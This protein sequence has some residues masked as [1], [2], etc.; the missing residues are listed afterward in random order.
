MKKLLL[1]IVNRYPPLFVAIQMFRNRTGAMRC[2]LE[3]LHSD[4]KLELEFE[5]KALDLG[6]GPAPKNMFEAQFAV[7]ADRYTDEKKNVVCVDL[8]FERLP[9]ED[10]WFHYI[11][12]YDLLEHIPRF[13]E[14]SASGGAPFIFLMN[15]IFR[16]LKPGGRFL[17]V[18]PIYPYLGAFQDPTHNNIITA[19]T[20]EMYFCA[21]KRDIA[22]H[23]GIKTY[24]RIIYKKMMGE[25]LVAILEK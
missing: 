19:D 23:Y 14:S 13:S 15:E 8:G 22:E 18:T 2:S 3:Q 4:F 11:T 10:D 21:G 7:G 16:I 9:F 12:A 1:Q 6:C 5:T 17:S 20:F 25:H 24:F